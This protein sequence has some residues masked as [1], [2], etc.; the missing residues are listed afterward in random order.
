MSQPRWVAW[1]QDALTGSNLHQINP[2]LA[3]REMSP[4]YMHCAFFCIC[5]NTYQCGC[6]CTYLPS[7]WL[8]WAKKR[9]KAGEASIEGEGAKLF[10][11]ENKVTQ[12]RKEDW[13]KN[14]KGR[15]FWSTMLKKT[16][17]MIFGSFVCRG[18]NLQGKTLFWGRREYT[19]YHG[20]TFYMLKFVWFHTCMWINE[21]RPIFPSVCHFQTK[22]KE[23]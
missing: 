20:C 5:V 23:T 13:D 12:G 8:A 15:F 11:L 19:L 17:N 16:W 22:K 1:R 21:Q 9:S 6:I 10:S 14:K 3:P 7:R 4:S 2:T 18:S